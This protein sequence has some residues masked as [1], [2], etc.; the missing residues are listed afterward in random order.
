MKRKKVLAA[1]LA[2][3][4]VMSSAVFPNSMSV[5]AENRSPIVKRTKGKEK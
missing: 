5:K 3:A 1:L 4:L 2:G